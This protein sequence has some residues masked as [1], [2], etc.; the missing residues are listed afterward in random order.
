MYLVKK[1]T[2]A[3]PAV[4]TDVE[5]YV[6]GSSNVQGVSGL[7]NAVAYLSMGRYLAAGDYWIGLVYRHS[8]GTAWSI[9]YDTG[10]P[11]P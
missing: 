3:S 8:S 2:L 10:G 4:L 1:I 7:S 9:A 11:A 5:A 6:V